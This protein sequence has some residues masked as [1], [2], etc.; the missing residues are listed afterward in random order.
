MPMT[1]DEW[2]A[3]AERN[4]GKPMT[5]A[6][7]QDQWEMHQFR[8]QHRGP[9]GKVGD[10]DA[11]QSGQTAGFGSRAGATDVTGMRDHARRHGFSED[12]ER[13]DDAT[14]QSWEKYKNSACP[15]HSPYAAINGTGCV[16]KPIDTNYNQKN[17]NFLGVQAAAPGTWVSPYGETRIGGGG[18][19]GGPGGGGRQPA[20][21]APTTFGSQI[22]YTG[23]PTVDMLIHQFNTRTNIQGTE[24]NIF[25]LG[26]DRRPGGEG[27]NADD[28]ETLGQLLSGGGMWWGQEGFNR[29][30]DASVERQQPQSRPRR[31]PRGGGGAPT[32]QEIA[33]PP[34]A[35]APAPAAPAPATPTQQPVP[36]YGGGPSGMGDMLERRFTKGYQW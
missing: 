14:L 29:G 9:K 36:V 2:R 7:A 12:F 15:P 32:P 25:G 3:A 8:V 19:G 11:I 24:R 13:F 22:S 23:N 16:E 33:A 10:Y 26:E 31:R 6:E 4:A 18:P 20:P 35:A 17:A 21:A 34:P 5:D 1:F 30:F 27:A 28:S